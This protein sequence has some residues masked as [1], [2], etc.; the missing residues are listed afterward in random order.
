MAQV[1]ITLTRSLIGY[2]KD[3]RA[4]VKALGLGKIRTSVVKED[5]ASLR[6]MLH[7]VA[8]LVEVKKSRLKE[9]LRCICMN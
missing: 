2:P 6:G 1:K 4:T 8:H 7:K 9:G 5:S 3:Q